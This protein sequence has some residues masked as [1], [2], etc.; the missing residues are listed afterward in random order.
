MVCFHC[1]WSTSPIGEGQREGGTGRAEGIGSLEVFFF[2]CRLVCNAPVKK[3][4]PAGGFPLGAWSQQLS[5]LRSEAQPVGEKRY[6]KKGRK[7]KL[8]FTTVAATTMRENGC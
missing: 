6:G 4:K 3:V 7:E 1:W 5:G 2:F 8:A